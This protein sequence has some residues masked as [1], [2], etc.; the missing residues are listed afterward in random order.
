MV[1]LVALYFLFLLLGIEDYVVLLVIAAIVYAVLHYKYWNRRVKQATTELV[2]ERQEE[3]L[4]HLQQLLQA[5]GM[6]PVS[7]EEIALF[8]Q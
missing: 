7:E 8:F 1:G 2:K 4:Q 5:K 3:K 6:A